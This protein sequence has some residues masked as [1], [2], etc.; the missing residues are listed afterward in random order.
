MFTCCYI[1]FFSKG[2]KNRYKFD[3]ARYLK[4]EYR[5]I[6]FRIDIQ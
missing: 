6:Y 1:T 3:K 2:I 4:A 5:N